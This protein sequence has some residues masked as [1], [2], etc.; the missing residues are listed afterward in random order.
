MR[1]NMNKRLDEIIAQVRIEVD[2]AT[3]LYPEFNSCHEGFSV[4]NEEVFELW[5][6]VRVKQG[7]R[8]IN[9]LRQ[10]ASQIA[11]MAIRFIYDNCKNE[12]KAQK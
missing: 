11:A 7:K 6:E 8:D 1:N 4:L 2:Y 9:R 5:E 10:E 3:N 12:E